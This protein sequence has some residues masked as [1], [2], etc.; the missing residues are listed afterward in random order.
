MLPKL[1][2]LHLRKQIVT[3][4]LLHCLAY[5]LSLPSDVNVKELLAVIQRKQSRETPGAIQK[6]VRSEGRRECPEKCVKAYKGGGGSSRTYVR[7]C[8][9]QLAPTCEAS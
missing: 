7:F 3:L 2:G 8:N 5:T 4:C 6:Y 1:F 9:S